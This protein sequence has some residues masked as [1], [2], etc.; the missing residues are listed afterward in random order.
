MMTTDGGANLWL[1]LADTEGHLADSVE[2]CFNREWEPT[3]AVRA[4]GKQQS[5][6]IPA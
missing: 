4:C 5:G 6:R 1:M 3:R 2:K